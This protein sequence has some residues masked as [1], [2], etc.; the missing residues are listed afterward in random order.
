MI[1]LRFFK[2]N[3]ALTLIELM[4]SVTIF[5]IVISS[6]FGSLAIGQKV[7]SASSTNI[8]LQQ[9]ARNAMFM[10]VK[11]LRQATS[12]SIV[13]SN[14]GAQ[15]DFTVEDLGSVRYDLSS[16]QLRRTNG[17]GASPDG[18]PIVLANSI[19][20]VVFAR[21]GANEPV[22]ISLNARKTSFLGQIIDFALAGNATPRN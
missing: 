4:A 1:P 6:I 15:I 18:R 19:N 22:T 3:K 8:A 21:A 7:W 10:M 17:S 13:I 9:N 16:N 11:E 20:T 2:K 12:T 14:A 5:L